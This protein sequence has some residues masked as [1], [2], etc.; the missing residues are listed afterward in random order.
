M[1]TLELPAGKSA[2]QWG[3]IHGESFRGAISSLAAIRTYLTMRIGEF[4]STE[5]MLDI[6]AAH[7]PVLERY[8]RDLH[9][10]VMGIAEGANLTPAQIVVVN[11]YTDL[12]DIRGKN[13][14]AVDIADVR[15]DAGTDAKMEAD[16]GDADGGC[17]TIF[18]R[19]QAGSFVAQ[20]WDMH[21][22]A[23][24]YILMLR[25]PETDAGPESW[26]FSI[27]GCLGMA[28]L[29]R[30]GVALAINNLPSTDARIGV[31]WPA[32]VRKALGFASARAAVAS[33]ECAPIGSGHHYLAADGD[34]AYGIETSGRRVRRTFAR[35]SG[36]AA[37]DG[38]ANGPAGDAYLHTNHC[39]DG[40]IAEVTTVPGRSTTYERLDWL[41]R[42]VD[43]RA[44]IDVHDAWQRLGSED[45]Y[46][47]S[48]CTNVSTPENPHG[49]ATCGA[50]AM[51]LDRPT[52]W[53]QAGL[54]HNVAAE[55]F[56]FTDP[57]ET[58]P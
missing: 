7:M 47:R 53:A 50:I 5:Q 33:I 31:L 44:L 4:D 10:E 45:G 52:V 25:V 23:I 21:A 56:D 1:R 42:S 38:P 51:E 8:D 35:E 34:S 28:G 16:I 41:S 20:T 6:A 26:L 13:W 17:S 29:N 12:R 30:H 57:S 48:V 9:D 14:P 43:E 39:L 58:R 32:L 3:Q 49:T 55:R 46:P 40:D 11:H 2:R 54:I 18:A 19:T 37:A 15:A 36:S 22:T 24:P 27:T